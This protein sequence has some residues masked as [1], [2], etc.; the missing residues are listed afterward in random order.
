MRYAA[1][2]GA[3]GDVCGWLE[4]DR[5][6]DLIHSR[7]SS[8]ASSTSTSDSSIASPSSSR[9]DLSWRPFEVVST[10]TDRSDS[11]QLMGDA[12]NSR[13]DHN[14]FSHL[15]L[16]DSSAGNQVYCHEPEEDLSYQLVELQESFINP[17]TNQEFYQDV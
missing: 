11:S 12:S 3:G 14:M 2:L 1:S 6:P 8:P 10:T 9:G 7:E 4:I 16:L 17:F 13:P 15:N 5:V